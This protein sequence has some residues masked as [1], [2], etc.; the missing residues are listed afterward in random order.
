VLKVQ[1]QLLNL[2]CFLLTGPGSFVQA[3]EAL[4]GR[5][6]TMAGKP[7]LLIKDFIS[8]RHP[9]NPERTIMIGDT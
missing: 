9:V 1:E 6:A 8:K 4:S 2:Y 3:V 5:K 7:G